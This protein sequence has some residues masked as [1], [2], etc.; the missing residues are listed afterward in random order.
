VVDIQPDG[1]LMFDAGALWV[2]AKHEIPFLIVMF[3][4]RAYYNDWEHQIRMAR[5]RG[6]PLERANIGMDMRGPAPDFAGL[7]RSMGWY[8]EGPIESPAEVGPAVQRAIRQVKD[9]KPALLDT[10][11][12]FR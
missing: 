10:V 5:L 3:N 4:N 11:T 2:A 9:G 6:T 8:A 7:A 1:D 12:R